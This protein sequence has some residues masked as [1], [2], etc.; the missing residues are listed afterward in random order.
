MRYTAEPIKGGRR[1]SRA[2]TVRF[3]ALQASRVA[4]IVTVLQRVGQRLAKEVVE[5]EPQEREAL[6]GRAF[7]E[8]LLSL[9]PTRCIDYRSC[10]LIV[11]VR[12]TSYGSRT[13]W[14]R[15]QG[16]NGRAPVSRVPRLS[17][18][19]RH[20]E[21]WP[22]VLAT[23]VLDMSA[24]L[25]GLQVPFGPSSRKEGPPE[26]P[27]SAKKPARAAVTDDLR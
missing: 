19:L 17:L 5:K 1:S 2:A 24:A 21:C 6:L 4:S 11:I 9:N 20:F 25:P 16:A 13:P 23:W 3:E 8:L 15:K 18:V 14:G 27:S 7:T 22:C 26:L 10:H 12:F